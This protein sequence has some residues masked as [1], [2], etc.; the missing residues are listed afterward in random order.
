MKNTEETLQIC[1]QKLLK[2]KFLFLI[3]STHFGVK[4]HLLQN[5]GLMWTLWMDHG[6]NSSKKWRAQ[7]GT[8]TPGGIYKLGN[9]RH[10]LSMQKAI[11]H[12]VW[13]TIK[14]C[15]FLNLI[16]NLVWACARLLRDNAGSVKLWVY[17]LNTQ[18]Q[19][20]TPCGKYHNLQPVRL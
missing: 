7:H 6:N 14:K 2:I 9:F 12:I 16:L 4:S 15:S 1:E 17:L 10:M 18:V 19:F 5:N 3:H 11:Y 8:T 13:R 20:W